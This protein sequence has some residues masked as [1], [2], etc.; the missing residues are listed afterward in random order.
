[1]KGKIEQNSIVITK[2]QRELCLILKRK[3]HWKLSLPLI[4]RKQKRIQG[5]K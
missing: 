3:Q 4:S 5:Q 1:V 2:P